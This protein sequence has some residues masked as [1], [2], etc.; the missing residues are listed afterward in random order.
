[1][2]IAMCFILLFLHETNTVHHSK[3]VII[4]DKHSGNDSLKSKSVESFQQ[5]LRN[6]DVFDNNPDL[7]AN[8]NDI[9]TNLYKHEAIAITME[10]I[11]EYYGEKS[12]IRIYSL[13]ENDYK[14]ILALITILDPKT[15]TIAL[16]ENQIYSNGE[17]TREAAL[18]HNAIL[19]INAGGFMSE[20][21]K[22]RPLGTTVLDGEPITLSP[23]TDLIFVGFDHNGNLIGERISSTEKIQELNIIN[24]AS[25][26][27]IILKDGT[28]Q[29]IPSN[30]RNLKEPRTIIG[31]L[32]NGDLVFMVIDGRKEGW[33][34]GITLEEAQDKLLEL[35]TL[36]AYNLDGGGSSTFY[37][38]GR[39]LNKPSLG[40]E[41][42]VV[43]NLL[44]LP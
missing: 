22:I 23:S 17:T 38:N 11:E 21:G 14:G 40:Y 19:G 20:N 12:V 24:G 15:I 18:R 4:S 37:F 32:E 35:N 44:I 7:E 28:R 6:V 27:P 26:L 5:S 36:N 34:N 8:Q 33:S 30:W 39:V 1:M 43:T 41:R 31:N 9:N 16:A 3:K 25:F 10:L 2:L 29:S 42:K 13:D